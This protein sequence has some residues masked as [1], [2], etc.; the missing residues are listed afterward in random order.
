MNNITK[1]NLT[2]YAEYLLNIALYKTGNIHDA[3]DLVQDTLLAALTYLDSGKIPENPKA[4]LSSV[5]NRKFYDS[6]RRKYRKPTVSINIVAELAEESR[7][8]ESMEKGEEAENI[9][10]C[11]GMLSK[12]YREVIVRHYMNGES[13]KDIAKALSV[14]ENTVKSRLYTGRTHI[15][16]EFEMENYAKQS[17]QPETLWIGT[18]GQPG[19]NDEPHSLVGNDKI[20]MNLLIL[21]YDKPVTIPELAGAIGIPTA[22]VEP[23]VEGLIKSELMGRSGDKVYTDF[24]IYTEKDKV[25]HLDAQLKVA[26]ENYREIWELVDKGLG[27]LRGQD[28]YKAQRPSAQLKLESHFVINTVQKSVL[29]V[30]NEAC[31]GIEPFS[32]Y[33]QRPDGGKWYAIGN[34]YPDNYDNAKSRHLPY[35]INGEWG[36]EIYDFLDTKYLTLNDYDTE[37]CHTHRLYKMRVMEGGKE[38]ALKMLYSVY[39]NSKDAFSAID[40]CCIDNLGR[41]IEMGFLSKDTSGKLICEVPVI[42]VKERSRYYALS[43]KYA[44]FISER[45]HNTFMSLMKKPL[46]I[47]SHVRSYLKWER[48][49]MYC[50]YLPMAI[51][52]MAK[53]EGLY[54][55]TEAPVYM[56]YEYPFDYYKKENSEKE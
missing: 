6:M 55:N 32:E 5:L 16:K 53:E 21:A 40:K 44:S 18:T 10:R 35:G 28:F 49:D 47:P 24:I 54:N 26:E 30:R 27:E 23:I 41:F 46:E 36:S 45:F 15:G 3:E 29:Y 38:S 34:R 11:V 2:E 39:S 8:Y 19:I 12:N 56:S 9:R 7:L 33:R 50:T 42:E 22:Y 52:L 13:V 48:Y 20:K 1:E 37:L 25:G 43:E 4:W 17:Y 51:V 31:G 14:P